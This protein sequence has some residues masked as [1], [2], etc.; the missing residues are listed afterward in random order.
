[1][2]RSKSTDLGEARKS[3]AITAEKTMLD[4]NRLIGT[5]QPDTLPGT[6]EK[7]VHTRSEVL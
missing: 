6:N 3:V 7:S 2:P 1:M 4:A 5:D